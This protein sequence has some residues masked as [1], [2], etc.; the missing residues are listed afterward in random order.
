MRNSSTRATHRITAVSNQV[1][2]KRQRY[3]SHL[4]KIT[5]GDCCRHA[6][7]PSP[8]QASYRYQRVRSS[9]ILGLLGGCDLT[10]AYGI[11]RMVRQSVR[12]CTIRLC[13]VMFVTYD[14]RMY[15][16]FHF[17]LLF[18]AF[19]HLGCFDGCTYS[20]ARGRQPSGTFATPCRCDK[21]VVLM[22]EV[23]V[24]MWM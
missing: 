10:G 21:F 1:A 6:D 11:V 2:C 9:L 23:C 16:L 4:L 22:I 18:L 13:L 12:G 14:T 7:P 17:F 15:V 20:L 3:A 5:P 8:F 24:F 19:C